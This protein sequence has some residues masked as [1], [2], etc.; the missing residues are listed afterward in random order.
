MFRR[1]IRLPISL[2]VVGPDRNLNTLPHV[3]T[4]GQ[5]STRF[6]GDIGIRLV[7]QIIGLQSTLLPTGLYLDEL[8]RLH[9]WE[10]RPCGLAL[11]IWP[12]AERVG[13]VGDEIGVAYAPLG[14]AVLAGNLLQP[15]GTSWLDELIDHELGHLL[16]LEEH[17]E[18][19]FMAAAL[20]LHNRVVTPQQRDIVRRGARRG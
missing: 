9:H 17:Q 19:T 6:W 14:F 13:L 7:P 5:E 10:V 20:E 15:G 12:M 8:R 16:G 18:G 1:P 3:L 2:V 11:Y 4:A